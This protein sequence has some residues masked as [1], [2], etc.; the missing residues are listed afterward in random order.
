MKKYDLYINLKTENGEI[1]IPIINSDLRSI[2]IYFSY[3]NDF[4]HFINTIRCTNSKKDKITG[5]TILDAN[6][7]L[8]ANFIDDNIINKRQLKVG[9]NDIY[10]KKDRDVVLAT[11]DDII[12]ICDSVNEELILSFTNFLK[13]QLK[14][15]EDKSLNDL[16][17]LAYEDYE[18]WLSF[19]NFVKNMIGKKLISIVKGNTLDEEYN[20]RIKDLPEYEDHISIYYQI[21][22]NLLSYAKSNKKAGN[23]K[24][25]ENINL[26]SSRPDHT[27]EDAW[28]EA[29][30]SQIYEDEEPKPFLGPNYEGDT[31]YRT[32]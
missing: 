29:L 6:S 30:N 21:T 22:D 19:A 32:Y 13:D 11:K 9:N 20:N 8:L 23:S 14:V 2:E 12:K 15:R 18:K 25:D 3:C 26:Y 31:N 17:N 16:I 7:V 4:T 28:N 24:I 10:Y 1:Q 5:K 27:D